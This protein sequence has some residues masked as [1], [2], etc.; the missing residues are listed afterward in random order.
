MA[1]YEQAAQLDP[2]M[3]LAKSGRAHAYIA[4]TDF[5]MLPAE[6]LA[7]AKADSHEAVRIGAGGFDNQFLKSRPRDLW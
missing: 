5:Y 2:Q 6:S 1:W 7:R 3:A 4:L